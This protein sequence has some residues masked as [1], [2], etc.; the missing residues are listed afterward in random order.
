M[1]KVKLTLLR[2]VSL[3]DIIIGGI[4]SWVIKQFLDFVWIKSK[5]RLRFEGK[6]HMGGYFDLIFGEDFLIGMFV[7]IL[8][9]SQN[10]GVTE[11]QEAVREFLEVHRKYHA[12][13]GT[14]LCSVCMCI[15]AFKK[16]LERYIHYP[17]LYPHKPTVIKQFW[18]LSRLMRK[19]IRASMERVRILVW[20]FANNID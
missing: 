18:A 16:H 3:W 5:P 15:I 9:H 10:K 17:E 20:L 7:M 12:S 11:Y 6:T 14:E 1:S 8:S 13:V 19:K 4:I 2:I